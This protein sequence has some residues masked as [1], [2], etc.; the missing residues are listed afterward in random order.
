MNSNVQERSC[1]KSLKRDIPKT[2]RKILRHIQ[3][4]QFAFFKS[5]NMATLAASS[6]SRATTD[7]TSKSNKTPSPELPPA[8]PEYS[9]LQ[10]KRVIEYAGKSQ[11]L[12]AILGLCEQIPE[13][14]KLLASLLA[15]PSPPSRGR[16]HPQRSFTASKAS[17]R[18]MDT[19]AARESALSSETGRDDSDSVDELK[20]EKKR[21]RSCNFCLGTCSLYS[22]HNSEPV[23]VQTND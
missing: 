3:T 8:F 7:L 16:D 4:L 22:D 2:A 14:A 18:V 11:L 9:I 10:L 15:L 23:C 20:K 5:R 6:A 13:A 17:R 19:T 1:I 12:D 21:K